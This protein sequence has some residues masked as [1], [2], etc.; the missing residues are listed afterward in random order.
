[1]AAETECACRIILIY[2]ATQV[3]FNKEKP[4]IER[5]IKSVGNIRQ[6]MP[7]GANQ[8]Q[9]VH[10]DAV[11]LYLEAAAAKPVF[12]KVVQTEIRKRYEE[13]SGGKVCPLMICAK[14]SH[15]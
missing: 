8:H 11:D 4:A 6:L 2:H 1:M 9:Q 5:Y 3:V 13:V 12:D 15:R 10:T 14:F 7:D